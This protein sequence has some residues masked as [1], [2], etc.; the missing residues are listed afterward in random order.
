MMLKSRG[1]IVHRPSFRDY[2]K[3][4]PR[5]IIVAFLRWDDANT[6]LSNARRALKNNPSKYKVGGSMKVFID[7]LYSP[8]FF[9]RLD[10][11]P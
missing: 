7:Q 10:K 1:L 5:P 2:T 11:K 8:N 6:I 9:L 4:T 3:S